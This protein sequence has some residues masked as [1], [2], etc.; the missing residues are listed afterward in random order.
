MC[1]GVTM[2]LQCVALTSFAAAQQGSMC[3]RVTQWS[4]GHPEWSWWWSHHVSWSHPGQANQ[5]HRNYTC[6]SPT[7]IWPRTIH[8]PAD[9]F[10]S[11]ARGNI[12]EICDFSVMSLANKVVACQS[13]KVSLVR[14]CRQQAD[15]PLSSSVSACQHHPSLTVLLAAES[16][17]LIDMAWTDSIGAWCREWICIS[18]HP[19]GWLSIRQSHKLVSFW[20]PMMERHD[21][22]TTDWEREKERGKKRE[23]SL[24]WYTFNLQIF[25]TS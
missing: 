22:T 10:V 7:W 4:W 15:L 14:L 13:C 6:S 20:G 5:L 18:E 8:N 21:I 11:E 25:F 23:R 3:S 16:S 9:S 19:E 12:L 2:L 1:A 17:F 24:I